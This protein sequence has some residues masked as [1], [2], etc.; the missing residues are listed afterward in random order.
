MIY[1]LTYPE[2]VWERLKFH[3]RGTVPTV[4][5]GEIRQGPGVVECVQARTP[6]SPFP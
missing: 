4:L 2:T 1:V 5:C 6:A 3:I